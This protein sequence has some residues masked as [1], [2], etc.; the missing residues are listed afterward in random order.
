MWNEQMREN[1]LEQAPELR[2]P[3]WFCTGRHDRTAPFELA[4]RYYDHLSAPSKTWI[5]FEE[6]G[7]EPFIDEP[8]KFKPRWPSCSASS[9]L[10]SAGTRG[11]SVDSDHPLRETVTRQAV[12]GAWCSEQ[13]SET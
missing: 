12:W 6:C 8:A 7:H 5:W 4:E 13:G 11:V 2:V 10:G 9:A 1:L 3:V